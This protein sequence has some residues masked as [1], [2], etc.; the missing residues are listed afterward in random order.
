MTEINK[1]RK[2]LIIN[3]HQQGMDIALFSAGGSV[4]KAYRAA[5]V[6]AGCLMVDNS[7]AFR[8]EEGVPLV[9]PEINPGEAKKA[10]QKNGGKVDEYII[11][12]ATE[13]FGPEN[14]FK[15]K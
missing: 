8:M 3:V 10:L 12:Q 4:S 7:S 15:T 13:D 9:V 1:S 5:C 11:E 6:N 2:E 14:I